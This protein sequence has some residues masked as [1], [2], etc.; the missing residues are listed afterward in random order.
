VWSDIVRAD[1]TLFGFCQTL[2]SWDYLSRTGSRLEFFLEN[3]VLTDC[4]EA[5]NIYIYIY[6]YVYIERYS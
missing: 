1:R 3:E 4:I 5:K 6:E 2:S